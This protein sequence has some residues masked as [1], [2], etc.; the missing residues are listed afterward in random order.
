MTAQERY[1]LIKSTL[2][3][4]SIPDA[5]ALR[6]IAQVRQQS[7]PARLDQPQSNG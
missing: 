2:H 3:D 7:L 1:D 6:R 5:E 4:D